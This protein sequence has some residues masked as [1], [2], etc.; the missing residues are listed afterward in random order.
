[1]DVVI[2]R[3]PQVVHD[4]LADV[5]GEVAL[6]VGAGSA[7][8]GDG[9]YRRHR[10]VEYGQIAAADPAHD[11]DHPA[12]HRLGLERVVEHDLDRPGLE[13]VGCGY[14]AHAARAP[15]SSPSSEAAAGRRCG[16]AWGS[17]R[18]GRR[19]AA[20]G[21]QRWSTIWARFSL[22][23][24]THSST[25]AGGPSLSGSLDGSL[26]RRLTRAAL[27]EVAELGVGQLDEQAGE[28]CPA[29]LADLRVAEA[30][31][32]RAARARP[33]SGR[34]SFH[35]GTCAQVERLTLSLF[36]LAGPRGRT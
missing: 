14:A 13:Q 24:V 30:A 1:M 33:R 28:E 21:G 3:A 23:A 8:D 31:G 6:Q 34:A 4:P 32:E 27:E 20:Y 29:R 35:T 12:R 15:A 11:P 19:T 26:E 10:E 2:H 17:S 7:G 9:R 25:L 22:K 36:L 5:G 16:A 18:S